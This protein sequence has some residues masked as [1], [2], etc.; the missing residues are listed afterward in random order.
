[1]LR[2]EVDSAKENG[3]DGNKRDVREL[4]LSATRMLLLR[5]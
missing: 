3:R 4:R 1:M 2:D 5:P